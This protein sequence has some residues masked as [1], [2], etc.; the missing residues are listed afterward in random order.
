MKPKRLA[1]RLMFLG[2]V[3]EILVAILHFLWPFQL[4]ETGHHGDPLLLGAVFIGMCLVTFGALSIYFSR[5]LLKGEEKAAL[6]YSASQAI[7]WGVMA[8]VELLLPVS[9]PTHPLENPTVYILQQ[10]VWMF[11]V[12]LVPLALWKVS[13]KV[14]ENGAS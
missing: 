6:V 14:K 1:G 5:R 13:K 8:L 12:F 10:S 9:V 4:I 3:I 11:L 2:G 7:L